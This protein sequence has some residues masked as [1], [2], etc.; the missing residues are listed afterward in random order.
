MK[1]KKVTAMLA[2][3]L[4]ACGT[5]AGATA[6]INEDFEF[7]D[8]T[9]K[10]T[11]CGD[12]VKNV[13]VKAYIPEFGAKSKFELADTMEK[14]GLSRIF[15]EC[16]DLE[17]LVEG[18]VNKSVNPPVVSKVTHEA[19]IDVDTDGCEAAAYTAIKIEASAAP[20]REIPE[21][22]EFRCD[23]PFIYYISDH[24]GTPF[25]MGI[26]NDPTQK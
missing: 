26:V 15:N 19:V 5:A 10:G 2:A 18:I 21:I 6:D 22:Y 11:T 14:A 13:E 3:L 17:P 12:G 23:R 20:M 9:L 25:F 16:A 4:M 8:D 7:E 24:M 1:M